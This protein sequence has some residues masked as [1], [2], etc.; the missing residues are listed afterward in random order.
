MSSDC[1]VTMIA[2]DCL[3][4]PGWASIS[5][6]LGLKVSRHEWVSS[7]KGYTHNISH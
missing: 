5:M 2:G 3:P 7:T 4:L 6:P 1:D